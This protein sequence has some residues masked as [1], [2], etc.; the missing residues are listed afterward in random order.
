MLGL[1]EYREPTSRLPDYLPWAALIAPGVVLQKDGCLQK[2]LGF[3]GPDLASSSGAELSSAVARLNNALKRLGSGWSFFV[4]A[5]RFECSRYPSSEWRHPA[6]WLVDMER[7]EQFSESGVHFE[8]SYFV[9]FVWQLPGTGSKRFS[10]LFFDDPEGGDEVQDNERD[11]EQFVKMVREMLDLLAGVFVEVRELDDD[12]TLTYL[13]STVSTNRHRVAAPG[14]PMYLDALLPDQAFT[15]GDIPMLGDEFIPTCTFTG[16][17]STTLPGMLDDL[18]HLGIEYRWVCRF[19]CLD[20][21]DARREL[22]R[23][24]K[25]WWQ[26]RKSLFTLLKEEAAGQESALLDSD[27]AN[28]AADADAALQELGDDMVAYGYLTCTVTVHHP[29][30]DEARRRMRLVKQVVQGRG[31]VVKDETLNS[32]EAWLGSLPGH[33]YA[34]VRRPVVNTLN[35]AHLMPLSAIWAGSGECAHLREVSGNGAP[36]VMC[37]TTGS[38]PFRLNLFVGDVG[39][40]LVVG[41]TGAGKSTLLGLLELQWLRYPGAR[42]VI[43]DKD[44]SARAATLAVGGRYYEPGGEHAPLAFQPFAGIDERSE[45]IW[46]SGFVLMMLREQGI[47]EHPALKKEVDMALQSLASSD[48]DHRTMTVFCDLVQSREVRDALRPYTVT[49]NYGQLFDADDEALSMGAW[50]MI[51]MNALMGLPGEA[52][53]PALYYLFHRVEQSFDG[54]PVLLVLDEAWLFLKH[55]V[56]MG[57]LQNW[58][59]TLR[60]KN[61]AVVFATQE[62]ADAADSP[63]MATILSACHTRIFLPDEEALAP[64]LRRAYETFGLTETEIGLLA[65]AQKK[66]DYY[67][68]SPLGRRMFSLDMGPVALAFAGMSSPEDQRFMDELEREA[69]EDEYAERLL[70][71]RGLDWAAEILQTARQEGRDNLKT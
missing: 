12:E 49:G 33:V 39:H 14:V 28:K 62:A 4:E 64:G 65:G 24:R 50:T 68:R 61:V 29:D 44:R 17:P 21:M 37:S 66:R 40:T 67:Y 11:L 35:L 34:N 53:A 43:F 18:N 36:H 63:M 71:Y 7:R 1:K 13:H 41:P 15:N 20:K 59:K 9:T 30:V 16:F 60:K 38:T 2:T 48:R 45:L 57:R 5:Q 58:L 56:F 32:R 55:P 22:E 6:A 52:V 19:L 46:A 70:R 42:V 25:R 69:A 54:Q 10:G 26:K 31:F 27:A 47:E 23:Y 3:R 51:E 8:S